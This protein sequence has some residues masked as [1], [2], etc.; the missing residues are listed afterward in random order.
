MH[1]SFSQKQAPIESNGSKQGFTLVELIV[2]GAII[3]ILAAI[4]I[5]V[6]GALKDAGR[7]TVDR[8]NIRQIGQASL[9]YAEEN[10]GIFPPRG[11]STRLGLNYLGELSRDVQTPSLHAIAAA[12]SRG[13]GLNDARVWVSRSD[14]HVSVNFDG[15]M[16]VL[17]GPPANRH[18]TP[19]FLDS[20]LSFAYVAG[21]NSGQ[22]GT[23]PIAFTRGLNRFGGDGKWISSGNHG[24]YGPDGGHIVYLA[25][26]VQFYKD[27]GATKASGVFTYHSGHPEAG[28]K[29]NAILD[30]VR[31]E[32]A[33]YSDPGGPSGSLSGSV[34][35]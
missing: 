11:G 7:R 31:F 26:H 29:T 10:R 1:C 5:P 15:Q 2:N 14:P 19:A 12:L 32:E 8:S 21:R 30:T 34:G 20:G 23:H 33:I 6:M 27:A 17:S 9:I 25:G 24:V 28:L 4:L 35:Y 18:L 16:T 3:G 22:S 13:S